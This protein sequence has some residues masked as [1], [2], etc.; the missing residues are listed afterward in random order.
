[1]K[2]MVDKEL[3][4]VFARKMKDFQ[5]QAGIPTTNGYIDLSHPQAALL[6]GLAKALLINEDDT[7]HWVH[8]RELRKWGFRVVPHTEVEDNRYWGIGEIHTKAGVLLYGDTHRS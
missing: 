2:N 8:I 5:K 6:S 4:Q 3:M 1:M 7:N